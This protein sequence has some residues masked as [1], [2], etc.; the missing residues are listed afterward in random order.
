MTPTIPTKPVMPVMPVMPEKN[1]MALLKL[2]HCPFLGPKTISLLENYFFDLEEIFSASFNQLILSGLRIDLIEKFIIWRKKINE[3][4]IIEKLATEKIKFIT[5]HDKRYPSLLKQITHPPAVLFYK[6]NLD[7][8]FLT[9][10]YVALAIVG[11]RQ[12]TIYAEKVLNYLLPDLIKNNIYIVSGLALGVDAFA[13]KITLQN[14]GLTI[15]VL[16]SG[17]SRKCFYPPANYYLAQQILENDGLILSE[18]TPQ[19][20]A[21]K[22]NFP[23]RN[24]LLSGLVQGVLIIEAQN[25]SGSLITANFALEQGR[26][27]LAVPGNIFS[28]SSM[29]TNQLIQNGA[30]PVLETTDILNIF[31]LPNLVNNKTK[32]T[33]ER[34]S[35]QP[36]NE[37]EKIIYELIKNADLL[38]ESLSV[39]NLIMKTKLDSAKINSTLTI[40]ELNGAIQNENGFL[41]LLS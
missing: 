8:F 24:R 7:K 5:W 33:K 23:R 29:G 12:N 3:A 2:V 38:A 20:P 41:K 13:H 17:L 34:T 30:W 31:S 26:E 14:N 21:R 18:F 39:D 10:N 19:E 1:L 27:V 25:K 11:A 9:K 28:N 22:Q 4:K 15:A 32:K 16:G 6:G 37:L 35:Y 36:N 40:L